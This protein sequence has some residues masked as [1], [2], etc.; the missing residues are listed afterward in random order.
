MIQNKQLCLALRG[1]PNR[2][3]LLPYLPK[4]ATALADRTH[5]IA[6]Q[7][8]L[9]DAFVVCLAATT[10]PDKNT[11]SVFTPCLR[12]YLTNDYDLKIADEIGSDAKA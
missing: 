8:K 11:R 5:P 6:Y 10:L 7:S 4:A 1:K 12:A 2:L 9:T 3:M